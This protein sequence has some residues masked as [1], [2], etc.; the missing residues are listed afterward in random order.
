MR[1]FA[2]RPPAENDLMALRM[3]IKAARDN[4]DALLARVDSMLPEAVDGPTAAQMRGWGRVQW[5]E[6][7][8]S[9]PRRRG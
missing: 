1:N 9:A 7:M 4:M 2:N 5:R 6:F 8:E 3:E